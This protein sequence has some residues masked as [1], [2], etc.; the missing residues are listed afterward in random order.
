MMSRQHREWTL[1]EDG[2]PTRTLRMDGPVSSNR[3]QGRILHGLSLHRD[4]TIYCIPDP[5]WTGTP[6]WE[7]KSGFGWLPWYNTTVFSSGELR[8]P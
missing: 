6:A 1:V 4:N 8:A 2:H 3:V 5:V 7:W